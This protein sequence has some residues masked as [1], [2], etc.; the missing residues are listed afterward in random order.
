MAGDLPHRRRGDP[1]PLAS[2]P[3]RGRLCVAERR[4]AS[5]PTTSP[6]PTT[7]CSRPIRAGRRGTSSPSSTRSTPTGSRPPGSASRRPSWAV[8]RPWD[9]LPEGRGPNTAREW[10]GGDLGGIRER[11]DHID[12]LGANLIYLTPFFPAGST[13]RYDAS[14]F[15]FVDPLLG[16]DEALAALLAAA[17]ERGIRVMGDLTLNH[18]GVGHEWFRSARDFPSSVERGFFYFDETAT[19]GYASWFDVPSLPKFDWANPELRRR[20]LDVVARRWLRDG[21][22][23]WR[24]DV[25]N[26]AGRHGSYDANRAVARATRAAVESRARR[27]AADRRAR[28]RLPSRPPGRRL[29]RDDELRRLPPPRLVVAAPRRPSRGPATPFLGAPGRAA[30][31]H[32]RRRRRDDARVPHRPPVG[33]GHALVDASLEP[34]RGALPHRRRLARAAA[35]R[36]R[37]PDDDARRADALRRRRARARGRLGRGRAPDDALGAH[38]R[39]G[40]GPARGLPRPRPSPPLERGARPR[41]TA[42]R[43]RLRRRDRVPA[44]DPGRAAPLPRRTRPAR[45]R[46]RPASPGSRP[47]TAATPQAASCPPTAPPST[48]GGSPMADVVFNGVDKVYENGFHAVHALSLEIRDREFMVIVGPS[49][50]GKSTLLCGSWPGAWRKRRLWER[51]TSAIGRSRGGTPRDGEDVAMVFQ[52]YA[53]YPHMSVGNQEPRAS[54]CGPAGGPGG[55]AHPQ[56]GGGRQRGPGDRRGCSIASR[57]SSPA[58]SVSGSRSDAR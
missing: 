40:R 15:D 45:A 36:R 57:R 54:A 19:H 46:D 22:D 3:R 10:F 38:G 47:S 48:S 7:S 17:H 12:R 21:L 9:A 55:G 56:A 18:C 32:R 2:R 33:V 25:A 50:C 26:M 5:S 16:G 11:L 58:E 37:P 41:R 1:L 43:P 52:D 27:R 13:H 31:A 35:R 29:A 28:P 6:T 30:G 51:C 4:S 42:L 23:G 44:R 8:P 20:L 53:L 39:L 14:S 49:G 34:R 24:I